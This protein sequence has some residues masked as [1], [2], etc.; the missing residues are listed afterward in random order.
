MI[1][2]EFVA[3]S[4]N[5]KIQISWRLFICKINSIIVNKQ[6]HLPTNCTGVLKYINQI[7][8]EIYFIHLCAEMYTKIYFAIY[9]T[10]SL[11]AWK[12]ILQGW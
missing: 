10:L 3:Y 8:P 2:T 9:V 4:K 12:R 1:N 5:S 6:C 7:V 11:N